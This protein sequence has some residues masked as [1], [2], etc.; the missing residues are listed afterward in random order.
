[1]IENIFFT[2]MKKN[3]ETFFQKKVLVCSEVSH[4][5]AL[6]TLKLL[7][8]K[9]FIIFFHAYEKYVSHHFKNFHQNLMVL[10]RNVF[11]N[12]NTF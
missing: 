12:Y 2:S 7:L 10:S 11:S 5:R 1:M 6:N 4:G 9:C 8:A 3:N